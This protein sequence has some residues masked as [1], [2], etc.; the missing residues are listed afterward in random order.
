M[1]AVSKVAFFLWLAIAQQPGQAWLTG[2]RRPMTTTTVVRSA[3]SSQSSIHLNEANSGC[4]R[5][6]AMAVAA[7]I[8]LSTMSSLIPTSVGAEEISAAVTEV[9]V[10]VSGDAKKVWSNM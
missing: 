1:T 4:D 9:Q 2:G 10:Q 7:S 8:G 3:R 6:E 5:R